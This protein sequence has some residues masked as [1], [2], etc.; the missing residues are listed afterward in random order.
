MLD[1][2]KI[3]AVRLLAEGSTSKTDIAE[4][5]GVS[6]ATLYN[7]LDDEEFKKSLDDT[8][9]KIKIHGESTIKANIDKY[10]KNIVDLSEKA[11]SQKVRLE[12]SMY[13]LD[14]VLGKSSTKVDLTVEPKSNESKEKQEFLN[15]LDDDN[16]NVEFEEVEIEE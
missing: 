10:I 4:I 11:E 1:E 14:R 5:V 3:V 12:A 6:R 9:H 15:M 7:W 13:L 8:L 16:I 2:K